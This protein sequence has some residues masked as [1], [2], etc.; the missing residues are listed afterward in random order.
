GKCSVK[1]GPKSALEP[2]YMALQLQNLKVEI[3]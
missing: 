1:K 3:K 2:I